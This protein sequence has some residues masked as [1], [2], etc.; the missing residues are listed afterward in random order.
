MQ[1]FSSIE[2][3]SSF[4]GS[5][6]SIL[7]GRGGGREVPQLQRRVH[8]AQP[9]YRESMSGGKT[10]KGDMENGGYGGRGLPLAATEMRR[11]ES[12]HPFVRSFVC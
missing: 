12:R 1:P 9:H 3:H 5:G 4:L 10:P 8:L 11:E 7:G 2:F 6:R